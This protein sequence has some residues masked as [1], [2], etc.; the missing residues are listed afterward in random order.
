MEIF[1]N[2]RWSLSIDYEFGTFVLQL[3]NG[4]QIRGFRRKDEIEDILERTSI[5]LIPDS[6]GNVNFIYPIY[7]DHG[8]I[9]VYPVN[10]FRNALDVLGA[11][12]TYYSKVISF[13]DIDRYFSDNDDVKRRILNYIRENNLRTI[14]LYHALS[15]VG[16]TDFVF[17]KISYISSGYY[18]VHT[19]FL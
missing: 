10:S 14:P 11:V 12:D 5:S 4:A 17:S 1:V 2:F 6:N 13:Y 19:L 16:V 9:A 3:P 7:N 8:E 18:S 15:F